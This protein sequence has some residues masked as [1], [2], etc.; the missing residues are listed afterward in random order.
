MADKKPGRG[1]HGAP[2][3]KGKKDPKPVEPSVVDRKSNKRDR[4][5]TRQRSYEGKKVT[6][7]AY[8]GSSAGYGNYMAAKVD[9]VTILDEN[10]RP[11]PFR[12]F[13]LEP[14]APADYL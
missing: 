13:P 4:V 6:P 12:D 9:G 7:V 10:G 1:G 2:K 11:I 14:N 3:K 8:S 5:P